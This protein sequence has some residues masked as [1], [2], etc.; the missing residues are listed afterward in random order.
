M[1]KNKLFSKHVYGHY[2]CLP[3]GTLSM[4]LNCNKKLA[5][6]NIETPLKTLHIIPFLINRSTEHSHNTSIFQPN[7][8]ISNDCNIIRNPNSLAP[9]VLH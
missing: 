2:L 3:P 7:S 6:R 5:K 4:A 9:S 1:R 8:E